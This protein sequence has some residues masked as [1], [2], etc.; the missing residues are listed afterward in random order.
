MIRRQSNIVIK[1]L[2]VARL[3]VGGSFNQPYNDQCSL[4]SS[5]LV[6]KVIIEIFYTVFA[7]YVKRNFP[8]VFR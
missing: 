7:P 6:F 4:N 1:G 3:V 8:Y 5:L 2:P